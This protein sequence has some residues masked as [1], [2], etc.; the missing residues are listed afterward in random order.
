MA[1][2][3]LSSWSIGE[4]SNV[5]VEGTAERVKFSNG[6]NFKD[7][8]TWSKACIAVNN[9]QLYSSFTLNATKIIGGSGI[10]E[11]YFGIFSNY[12][13]SNY[14]SS[15][16][17]NG[18]SGVIAWEKLSTSS[19]SQ[20]YTVNV[21]AGTSGT[22]YIGFCFYD[23]STNYSMCD[24][25]CRIYFGSITGKESNYTV[26]L[27]AGTGI[28]AVSQTNS[29]GTYPEGTSVQ[30]TATVNSGYRF[31]NWTGYDTQTANPYTFTIKQNRT[32]TANAVKLYTI[33][34][35]S[36]G[37]SYVS[38]TSLAQ[39]DSYGT[40]S[41]PTRNGYTF[42]G[43]YTASSGGT[44]ISST[45]VFN[46]TSNIT[47]YAQWT[48]NSY[49]LTYDANGGTVLTTSK[50]IL[51]DSTYG[52]LPTPTRIGYEFLGWFTASSGGI[53]ITSTTKY[54]TVG[55]S[56]LYAHWKP[57]GAVHICVDNIWTFAQ[58]YL[59]KDN[60]WHL[61]IPYTSNNQ[62]WQMNVN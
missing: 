18:A 3:N 37:G 52:T 14:S 48:A 44:K 46:Y 41:N 25:A 2:L 58:V 61:T 26:K 29:S 36:Q 28:S 32:Y 11:C 31:K 38:P 51:Y 55:N 49:I 10:W 35:D 34:F 21:P 30:I 27:N 5:T 13:K 50:S 23:N 54:T 57:N 60:N 16:A 7:S 17:N 1:V 43:W 33:T 20:S 12:N 9:I 19:S 4:A 62:T 45:S 53:Q 24:N 8:Q 15:A 6:G 59:F 56:T 40:L 39:G 47:I 42:K 22:A